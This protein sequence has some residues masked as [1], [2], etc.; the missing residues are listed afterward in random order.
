MSRDEDLSL[1]GSK[2]GKHNQTYPIPLLAGGILATDEHCQV[3]EALRAAERT[4]D[5]RRK[6]RT[7]TKQGGWG[8]KL[9][10]SV[11]KKKSDRREHDLVRVRVCG[12]SRYLRVRT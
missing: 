9:S 2:F 5:K 11:S 12:F 6:E 7:I 10:T 1:S 3:R 4:L 8:R